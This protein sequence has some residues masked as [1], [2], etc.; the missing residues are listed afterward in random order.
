MQ[1]SRRT[2]ATER[3]NDGVPVRCYVIC[4]FVFAAASLAILAKSSIAPR[5]QSSAGRSRKFNFSL[6][7]FET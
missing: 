3:N 1:R 2:F 5:V 7:M 6:R 4:C